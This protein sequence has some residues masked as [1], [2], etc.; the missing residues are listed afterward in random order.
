[1]SL[2]YWRAAFERRHTTSKDFPHLTSYPR[3]CLYVYVMCSQNV[4]S[5]H[6][7]AGR[8]RQLIE[9]EALDV[10]GVRLL[11][12]DEADK[13]MDESFAQQIK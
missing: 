6:V 8:L 7:S 5:L 13:L 10:T 2:V 9:L 3:Y 11:I 12:L 1:M 4:Q